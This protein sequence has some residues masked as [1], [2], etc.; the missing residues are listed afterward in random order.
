MRTKADVRPLNL[1]ARAPDHDLIRLNRIMIPSPRLSMISA[2]RSAFVARENRFPP[3]ADA[4]L[5]VRI[6]LY[7][8]TASDASLETSA[9]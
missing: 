1:W 6:M 9:L 4:A 7:R 2:Q 3:C 8:G 5:R